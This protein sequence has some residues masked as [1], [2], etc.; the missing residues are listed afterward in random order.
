MG[1]VI[2]MAI[3]IRGR[4]GL[5]MAVRGRKGAA[6]NKFLVLLEMVSQVPGGKTAL[7][8]GAQLCKAWVRRVNKSKDAS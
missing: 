4:L 1:V 2:R 7:P 3:G 6:Q 5:L 8:K